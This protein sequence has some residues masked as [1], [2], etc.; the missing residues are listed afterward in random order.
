MHI[1]VIRG[2]GINNQTDGAI[3]FGNLGLHAAKRI[4]VTRNR[5]LA[6]HI[7][8]GFLQ[9]FVVIRQAVVNVNQRRGDIRAGAIAVVKRNNFLAG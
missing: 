6:L 2:I 3:F 7:D 5:D 4:A 8:A 9:F 1:A